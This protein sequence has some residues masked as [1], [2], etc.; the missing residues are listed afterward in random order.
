MIDCSIIMKNNL[1]LIY[2]ILKLTRNNYYLNIIYL[3]S[4]FKKIKA[5][6]KTKYKHETLNVYLN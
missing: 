3:Y 6:I 4:I 2:F 5:S 1:K